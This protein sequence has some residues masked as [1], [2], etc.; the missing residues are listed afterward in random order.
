VAASAKTL[1]IVVPFL[2]EEQN[3]PRLYERVCNAMAKEPEQFEI[4]FVDDGSSDGSAAWVAEQ[5]RTDGRV[6]LL[7]L[8][9]NFGHQIAI[10]AGLDHASGDATVIIDADLQDPP[11]VIPVLLARWREGFE[12]VYAARETRAGETWLK[13]LLAAMFYR[14]FRRMT[15][16]DVEM[17]LDAGDFRLVDARVVAALRRVRELHRFMR[18]LTS[19]VGFRQCAVRYHRAAREA[20]ETKYPV[21]KSVRLAIDAIT[22]FSGAPLRWMMVGGLLISVLGGGLATWYVVGR[23][24]YPQSSQPGWATL[25][26]V[27]LFMGGLQ[28]ACLGLL[29]L[30]VGRTFEQTKGRP[31]YLVRESIGLE[32]Q[33]DAPDANRVP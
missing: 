8:S 15:S 25:I 4:I 26:S 33:R 13:R 20:G 30:Y 16:G 21:R 14:S 19:W 10:T 7:R 17:P 1:S 32:T 18:G 27:V 31:L 28:L 3:L 2:D 22:S 12:V 5:A 29:G 6:R 11:E 23:I 24:L 9:R